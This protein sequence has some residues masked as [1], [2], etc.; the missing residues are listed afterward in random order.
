MAVYT[1]V[2]L[3]ALEGF[4]AAY[5]VG[6][7]LSFK[8]IAEGV[9]NS[10]FF[11]QTERGRFILTLYE[12]RVEAR[13]VPFFLSLMRH[14]SQRGFPCPLPVV[15]GGGAMQSVLEGRPAALLQFLD[16]VSVHAPK[17]RHCFQVGEILARLHLQAGD[18]A[19]ARANRLGISAWRGLLDVCEKRLDSAPLVSSA[20]LHAA[21]GAL[22]QHWPQDLPQGVVHADLFPD[23]VLFRA[24]ALEGVIDFY[25]ACQDALAYD[26]AVCINAWC[27]GRDWAFVAENA[28]ALLDGYRRQR[29]LQA[30]EFES[31]PILCHGA[32][33]R[34]LLTRLH[35]WLYHIDGSLV[36]PKDPREYLAKLRFHG[37][38]G[39]A[40]DYGL[41]G[42]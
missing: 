1:R 25:F 13:D 33:M 9:E 30:R 37:S 16:G 32:A 24:D 38:I 12:K 21:M 35:D 28:R 14:L 18:F 19:H 3:D 31:L 26:I 20:E 42:Q 34:F 11:L 17:A 2:S 4:L 10:N 8:G 41:E 15:D 40:S 6:A 29:P 7:V 22:E 27:F 5:D 23:N 36:S 39:S